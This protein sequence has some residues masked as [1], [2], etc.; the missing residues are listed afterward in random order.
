M[1]RSFP[2]FPL[3]DVVD[4]DYDGHTNVNVKINNAVSELST[5]QD[6]I[7]LRRSLKELYPLTL[8]DGKLELHL[9]DTNIHLMHS[10]L[11]IPTNFRATAM[12]RDGIVERT[13]QR[14]SP[15]FA[16][17]PFCLLHPT[18]DSLTG[19]F[20]L[21]EGINGHYEDDKIRY[22]VR[23]VLTNSSSAIHLYKVDKISN[24]KGNITHVLKS[25]IGNLTTGFSERKKRSDEWSYTG[26]HYL[27]LY[28]VGDYD[29]YSRACS[30]EGLNSVDKCFDKIWTY[31]NTVS[32]VY[33]YGFGIPITVVGMEVWTSRN[34]IDIPTSKQRTLWSDGYLDIVKDYA[35][36]LRQRGK[37]FDALLY[38]TSTEGPDSEVLGLAPTG[39][40]CNTDNAAYV[41]DRADEPDEQV[42]ITIAHELGHLF[43]ASHVETP[44]CSC[45]ESNNCVLTKGNR[46][47]K[48]FCIAEYQVVYITCQAI[49]QKLF[50]DEK[51]KK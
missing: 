25:L 22:T 39:G 3:S 29:F 40:L 6:I 32:L 26:G 14:H 2:F 34:L 48:Y 41:D 37:H 7:Y 10:T 33:L 42:L 13:S 19:L 46:I 30:R 38:L 47:N 36:E 50:K 15:H 17:Q 18:E 20:N 24:T 28:V 5:L 21:C 16:N 51:C 45:G 4:G 43:G 27:E 9:G 44:D 11:I 35:S 31:L 12:G 23:S 1:I 49:F 8:N